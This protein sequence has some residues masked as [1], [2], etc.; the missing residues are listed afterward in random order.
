VINGGVTLGPRVQVG[1]SCTIGAD[2]SITGPVTI[3]RGVYI[4]ERCVLEG[5]LAI[6]DFA[7]LKDAI[8]MKGN[9]SGTE[10]N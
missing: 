7:N 2:T 10:P 8:Y 3:G 9:G 5:P 1:P 4:G 6:E